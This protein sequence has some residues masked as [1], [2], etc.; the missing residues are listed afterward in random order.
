MGGGGGNTS[1]SLSCLKIHGFLPCLSLYFKPNSNSCFIFYFIFKIHSNLQ[2]FFE[3]KQI[4]AFLYFAIFTNSNKF[5]PFALSKD[6]KS[7]C[8]FAA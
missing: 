5:T 3:F 4:Q 1:L 6:F 2:S 8:K 7:S